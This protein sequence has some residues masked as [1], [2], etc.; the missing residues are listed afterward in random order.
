MAAKSQKAK[1]V[2][3]DSAGNEVDIASGKVATIRYNFSHGEN[4]DVALASIGKSALNTC[5]VRGAAEKIR[6]DYAGAESPE[7]AME[8]AEEVRD[9]FYADEWYRPTEGGGG[10]SVS[11]F[12]EA[13]RLAKEKDGHPF[14]EAATRA[15]WLGKNEDGT[16]RA[17]NRNAALA[18]NATLRAMYA[19]LQADRASAVAARAAERAAKAATEAAGT[20]EGDSTNL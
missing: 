4:M 10:P 15:K 9:L 5:T 12:I 6:D 8:W 2:Y 1:I 3:L 11:L 16:S 18:G 19:K 7:Q 17:K 20:T 14:D 13:V